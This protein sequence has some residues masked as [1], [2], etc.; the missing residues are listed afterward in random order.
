[1]KPYDSI[2]TLAK[3]KAE[4]RDTHKDLANK[5]TWRDRRTDSRAGRRMGPIPRLFDEAGKKMRSLEWCIEM[6]RLIECNEELEYH[7]LRKHNMLSGTIPSLCVRGAAEN[8][9]ICIREELWRQWY[10]YRIMHLSFFF[11]L[12]VKSAARVACSNT[13]R[14]PSLVLAEH[15]KYLYAPIFLRTSSPCK[16]CQFNDG[17]TGMVARLKRSQ[18]MERGWL[19]LLVQE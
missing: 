3:A 9:P 7:S 6:T 13:S 12:F 4:K 19:C 14:T 15:S 2:S 10:L 5:A 17:L 8:Y 1:M 11:F 18:N 16:I